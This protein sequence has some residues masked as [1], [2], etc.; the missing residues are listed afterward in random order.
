MAHWAE[1]F[2]DQFGWLPVLQPL[3]TQVMQDEPW[4]F[5]LDPPS[6]AEV[7][8]AITALN[9]LRTT[10]PD[11]LPPEVRSSDFPIRTYLEGSVSA[12]WGESIM[13]A[14]YKQGSRTDCSNHRG[15]SLTPVVTKLLATKSLCNGNLRLGKS[16]LVSAQN[17]S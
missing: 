11:S 12:H 3:P 17:V 10:G 8:N 16:R 13:M 7:Q 9:R 6:K 14:I 1:H 4:T 15:I 2:L 5:S